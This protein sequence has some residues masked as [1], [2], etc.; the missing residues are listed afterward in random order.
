[1]SWFHASAHPLLHSSTHPSILPS[2]HSSIHPSIQ[3]LMYS[4]IKYIFLNEEILIIMPLFVVVMPLHNNM[5]SGMR[6]MSSKLI[7]K[8]ECERLLIKVLQSLQAQIIVAAGIK[9]IRWLMKALLRWILRSMN[10]LEEIQWRGK[11]NILV[12]EHKRTQGIGLYEQ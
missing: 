9:S 12:P 5:Y 2:T 11:S 3:P 7:I 6:K 1:M 4:I 8:S 10:G